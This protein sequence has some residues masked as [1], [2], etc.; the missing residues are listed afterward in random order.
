MFYELRN[1]EAKKFSANA[2]NERPNSIEFAAIL[3]V[4]GGGWGGEGRIWWQPGEETQVERGGN[5]TN[6][7]DEGEKLSA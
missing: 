4:G 2:L 5:G 3:N 1:L 7:G 6:G